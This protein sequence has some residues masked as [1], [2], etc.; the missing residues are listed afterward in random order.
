MAPM[1][2]ARLTGPRKPFA[3]RDRAILLLSISLQLILGLLFGHAYDIRIFMATGY[4]V[5]SGRNPY[6][7]QDLTAVFGN[8]AFQGMTSVG[9]PPPWPLVLGLIYRIIHPISHNLLVYNLAIKV[10]VIAANVGL[11]YLVCRILKDLGADAGVSRRAWVFMLLNPFLLFFA[12]AWGQF[13]SIVA[14]LALWSLLLLHKG[15]TR[16]SAVFLALAVSLKPTA[17]PIV[18]VALAWLM[19]R[20]WQE[21]IRYLAVLVAGAL[22]FCV[23]PFA[24][25]GWDPSPIVTH[26]NAHFS[27]AGAM[28]FMTFFE[29]LSNSYQLPGN[30]WLLGLA[31]IPALAFGL[32][33]LRR[34]TGGFVDLLKNS[35]AL[36]LVFYLTRAWLSEPNIILVLPL[37]LILTSAGELDRRA[38]AAM[39]ILPL[40]FTFFNTSPPQLLFPSFPG[41]ME[42]VLGLGEGLR[43]VR[44]SLK[45][46]VVILWQIAGWWIVISCLRRSPAPPA[47]VRS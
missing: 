21:A 23:A 31:W 41:A 47:S 27:V 2:L 20:S 22:L 26:W 1:S 35:T 30:W 3:A 40:V 45:I 10:P 29:L 36:V 14:L 11:A 4:L 44:L 33:A 8:S 7:A 38:L 13:D 46:A 17:L 12:S 6:V 43:T 42:K 25:F 24:I 28:S 32:L 5:A 39:W 37:V 15:R 19:G 9:Y 16:S 18:L 34:N